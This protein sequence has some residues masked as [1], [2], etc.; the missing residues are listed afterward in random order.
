MCIRNHNNHAQLLQRYPYALPSQHTRH[1]KTDQ[2][3]TG[4]ALAECLQN[5]ECIMISRHKPSECLRPP[6]LETLPTH[7]QQLKHSYG[8]CKRGMVDMRKR[9]RGNQPVGLAA[10]GAEGSGQGGQ[11]YA[12]RPAFGKGVKETAGEEDVTAAAVE[13]GT[14]ER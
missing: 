8:M 11:L 10:D 13:G 12:G 7:C 4:A 6:L 14:E 2:P 5:S 1:S 3:P 9:F